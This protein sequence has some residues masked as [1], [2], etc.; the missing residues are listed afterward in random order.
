MLGDITTGEPDDVR[1]KP[2]PKQAQEIASA[3]IAELGL[4]KFRANKISIQDVMKVGDNLDHETD[5]SELVS[6]PDRC[7]IEMIFRLLKQLLLLDYTARD[8][9]VP[10]MSYEVSD[11]K[12][13][14]DCECD[15]FDDDDGPLSTALHPL[16]SLV[17]IFPLCQ[18]PLQLALARKLFLCRLAVPLVIPNVFSQHFEVLLMPQTNVILEQAAGCCTSALHSDTQIVSF[19]RFGS[20][21]DYSK[22]YLINHMLDNTGHPT[23]VNF[24]CENGAQERRI[25]NG[26][27]DISWSLPQGQSLGDITGTYLNLHGDALLYKEQFE[28]LSG[29]SDV[30]V[31]FL[32]YDELGSAE[33]IQMCNTV[34]DVCNLILLVRNWKPNKV[35]YEAFQRGIKRLTGCYKIIKISTTRNMSRVVTA[36]NHYIFD[37]AISDTKLADLQSVPGWDVDL[38]HY[39]AEER[40]SK[41]IVNEI[42]K[43]SMKDIKSKVLPLQGQNW[44]NWSA[45]HKRY[46]RNILDEILTNESKT[47]YEI[48]EDM[49]EEMENERESQRFILRKIPNPMRQFIAALYASD[50]SYP[51]F[52]HF[53]NNGLNVKCQEVLPDLQDNLLDTIRKFKTQERKGSLLERKL[54]QA[55]D[56]IDTSSMGLEHFF[57][58]LSQIYAASRNSLYAIIYRSL[59]ALIAKHVTAG[60]P[61]EII[62]GDV[63]NIEMPWLVEV[64]NQIKMILGNKRVLVLSVLG[65]QSSGKSTLLNTMFGLQ[66]AVSGGR[67]TKGVFMQMVKAEANMPFDYVLVLDTEGLRA[68]ELSN[69]KD[70]SGKARDNELATFVIGIGDITIMN[71]KGENYSQMKDVMQIAVT[72]FFKMTLI[73]ENFNM[74]KRCVF[75]H[76]NASATDAKHKNA[77]AGGKLQDA[78]DKMT[79]EAA[80]DEGHLCVKSFNE[81]IKFD[82]ETDIW[83]FPNFWQGNPPMGHANPAYSSA[84]LKVRQGIFSSFS[85]SNRADFKTFDSFTSYLQDLWS[86][87]L[88]ENFV[89]SF[90]NCM[91]INLYGELDIECRNITE[92]IRN[93]LNTWEE[94]L[95][96]QL[97]SQSQSTSGLYGT[98]QKEAE[99]E[100]DQLRQFYSKS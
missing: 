56:H 69:K 24:N 86:A 4:Q 59:P 17:L 95:A 44:Q 76:Q 21:G 83:F 25:S 98:I 93:D 28:L 19:V 70:K 30:V 32:A 51:L 58:E 67:C 61:F 35:P 48:K 74:N 23:F 89:F 49:K 12:S 52:F 63:S 68:A 81:I 53:L 40:L 41:C 96:V 29:K 84:V 78:L 54:D 79:I 87:I 38:T 97:T 92:N 45:I 46:F 1:E 5:T 57:R 33:V 90:T 15:M 72:A 100:Q 20:L 31:C 16:D 26:L 94:N 39:E 2:L 66:F 62:N 75:I 91:E 7:P 9:L 13:S 64:F 42:S 27:V 80:R 55:I 8:K 50:C 34:P 3:M 99:I 60:Q 77:L 82:C 18:P 6:E 85:Q 10:C 47:E 22:S 43:F 65:I 14:S 71:I 37:S 88:N 11:E 73:H 36:L